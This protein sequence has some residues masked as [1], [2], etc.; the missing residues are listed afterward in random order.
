MIA[1]DPLI[2]IVIRTYFREETLAKTLESI[3]NSNYPKN[4][5]EIIVVKDL[6]DQGA[7]NV[8]NMF[9]QKYPEIRTMLLGLSVNSATQARNLGIKHSNG[10][11]L[12]ISDDDVIIHPESMKRA[13]TLLNADCK[14]AAVTFPVMF[15]TPPIHAEVHHM[16]FIGTLTKNISAV[17][18]LT[19]HRKKVLEKVGLY[20][21]DMG[22]PLTIHED[23]EL[24]SRLRKNGYTIII[25]GTIVQRHLE[26]LRK[27]I[28]KTE[29]GNSPHIGIMTRVKGGIAA[30][31]SYANSYLRRDY[32][33]FFEVMKSSPVSQQVEYAIYFLMPLIGLTLLPTPLYAL[34]YVLLL[35][36]V[37]DAH[38]FIKGYYRVFGPQKRL[39]Y[40][41]I[42]IFV[43]VVRTYLSVLGLLVR[44]PSKLGN[45][46]NKRIGSGKIIESFDPK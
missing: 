33:T 30:L 15:D 38:S 46:I 7:E 43:R 21:E 45:R 14:V 25:D 12:G 3:A 44:V 16:R 36:F 4:K 39:L 27:S 29:S 8:V 1:E 9:K 13:I 42:L 34:A 24:G 20:R 2:S 41:I 6:K 31:R 17:M 22:P 35:V 19:F 18:P 11:I 37:V 26:A 23:W 5:I 10:D 40:P 28:P 32:W